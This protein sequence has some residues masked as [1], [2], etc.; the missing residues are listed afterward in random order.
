MMKTTK[1]RVTFDAAGGHRGFL[2]FSSGNSTPWLAVYTQ[3]TVL[4][5]IQRLGNVTVEKV[6]DDV[7]DITAPQWSMLVI[8]P[9]SGTIEI[10]DA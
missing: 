6:G 4:A 9:L 1:A 5:N 7:C 8:I 2:A 3:N 10:T